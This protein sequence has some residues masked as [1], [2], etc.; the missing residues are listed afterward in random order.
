MYFARPFVTLW[1]KQTKRL[2]GLVRILRER[3]AT[4]STVAV[5]VVERLWSI[6]ISTQ[7]AFELLTV[8]KYLRIVATT[9]P[10]YLEYV[11]TEP[12]LPSISRHQ[13]RRL[14]DLAGGNQQE[15]DSNSNYSLVVF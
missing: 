8:Q 3:T 2:P 1:G 7:S 11:P 13:N 15:A 10:Q 6:E 14:G 12:S 4:C 5:A 9:E